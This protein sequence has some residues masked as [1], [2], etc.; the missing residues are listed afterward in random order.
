MFSCKIE[1]FSI[2]IP[3]GSYVKHFKFIYEK[4]SIISH[5]TFR[6]LVPDFHNVFFSYISS[7]MNLLTFFLFYENAT[8]TAYRFCVPK[9]IDFLRCK[10][11]SFSRGAEKIAIVFHDDRSF[12]YHSKLAKKIFIEFARGLEKFFITLFAYLIK[13]ISKRIFKVL[14]IAQWFISGFY[15]NM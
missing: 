4:Y 5:S 8:R 3:Y 13:K 11:E 14:R 15:T 10:K 6:H 12:R 7:R 1:V 2:R 9:K